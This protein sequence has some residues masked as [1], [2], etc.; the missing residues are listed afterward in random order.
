MLMVGLRV[1]VGKL[2]MVFERKR[3]VKGIT[4]IL[5]LRNKKN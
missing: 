1:F 2:D 3:G 5:G 4:R